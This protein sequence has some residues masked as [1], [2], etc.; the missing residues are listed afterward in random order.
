[1]EIEDLEPKK[2]KA[3]ELG[4]NLD[5]LSVGELEALIEALKA[6]TARVQAALATRQSTRSAA[7]A[8]FKR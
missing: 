3:H 6:E 5:R 2:L 8:A 7:E 4:Q 1:M